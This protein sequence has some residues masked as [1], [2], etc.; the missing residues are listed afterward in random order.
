MAVLCERAWLNLVNSDRYH[1][2]D[3]CDLLASVEDG[4]AYNPYAVATSHPTNGYWIYETP[5]IAR[6]PKVRMLIEIDDDK[7]FAVLCGLR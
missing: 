1:I 4:L 6:L 5:P 3:L 2:D 7:K